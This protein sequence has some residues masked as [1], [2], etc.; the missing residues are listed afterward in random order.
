MLSGPV[1]LLDDALD[2]DA[3][4]GVDRLHHLVVGDGHHMV[5]HQVGGFVRTVIDAQDGLYQR[6]IYVRIIIVEGPF[7]LVAHLFHDVAGEGL[8]DV[9][10]PVG[11]VAVAYIHAVAQSVGVGHDV[12]LEVGYN[13]Q[14]GVA[15]LL[16]Q[17]AEDDHRGVH[18]VNN[19]VELVA[20]DLEGVLAS[21]EVQGP[22]HY[23]GGPQALEDVVVYGN[24]H[25]SVDRDQRHYRG[26]THELRHGVQV[27]Q[28][29]LG[30]R[31]HHVPAPGGGEDASAVVAGYGVVGQLKVDV[32]DRGVHPQPHPG[33]Q[34]LG[35]EHEAGVVHVPDYLV[36]DPVE[37]VV[38]VGFARGP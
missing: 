12:V 16:V 13:S 21:L 28:V 11:L 23:R 18:A 35:G 9:H 37:V 20:S 1:D 22:G 24:V 19:L 38:D 34:S 3:V 25:G 26:R 27:A 6:G 14:G 36:V 15:D 5:D 29:V 33:G 32:P 4:V 17:I 31:E 8:F 2:G 10:G 30:G 7:S